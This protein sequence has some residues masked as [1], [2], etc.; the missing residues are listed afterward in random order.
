MESVVAPV[1][2]LSRALLRARTQVALGRALGL[3]Q[4]AV[5]KRL[6]AR[7]PVSAEEAIL[8]ERELGI[9][10]HESRPDLFPAD[11]AAQPDSATLIEAN[12]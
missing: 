1:D 2:I 4:Q 6:K 8:L 10:R 12:R 5:S 11:A 3:T 7:R 9:P